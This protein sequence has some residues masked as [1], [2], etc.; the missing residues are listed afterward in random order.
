MAFYIL[1]FRP[2]DFSFTMALITGITISSNCAVSTSLY[3]ATCD[4]TL[5]T[6]IAILILDNNVFDT[7]NIVGAKYDAYVSSYY[8]TTR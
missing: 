2:T 6:G 1:A 4:W 8:T 7:T 3:N 5:I